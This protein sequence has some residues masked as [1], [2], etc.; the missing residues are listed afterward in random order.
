MSIAE[1]FKRITRIVIIEHDGR[2]RQRTFQ[3]A[4]VVSGK[5]RRGLPVYRPTMVR[6]VL[7]VSRLYKQATPNFV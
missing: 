3:Y 4:W 5:P 2:S 1:S 6:I 7:V